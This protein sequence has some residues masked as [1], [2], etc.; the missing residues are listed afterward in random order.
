[1]ALN[2]TTDSRRLGALG[3]GIMRYRTRAEAEWPPLGR[4]R[5]TALALCAPSPE[6]RVHGAAD[7]SVFRTRS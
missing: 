3:P 1:M 4:C 2:S 6:P 7:L 5:V